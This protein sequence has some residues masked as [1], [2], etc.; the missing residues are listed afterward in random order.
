MP[1]ASKLKRPQIIT[2]GARLWF[3]G[4]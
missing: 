3:R 2:S 4:R 1:E